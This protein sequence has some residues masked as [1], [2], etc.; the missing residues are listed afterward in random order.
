MRKKDV[1]KLKDADLY[2]Y[3]HQQDEKRFGEYMNKILAL[4]EHEVNE[5]KNYLRG[6]WFR[7]RDEST[8]G[9]MDFPTHEVKVGEDTCLVYDIPPERM[10]EALDKANPF[11]GEIFFPVRYCNF[12]KALILYAFGYNFIVKPTFFTTGE[13]AFGWGL[14]KEELTNISNMEKGA[15]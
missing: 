8:K 3:R 14:M 2:H 12:G 5:K 11:K 9:L 13:T 4:E 1:S 15:E 7:I 10:Q 6:H